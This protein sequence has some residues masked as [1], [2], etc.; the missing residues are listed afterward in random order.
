MPLLAGILLLVITALRAYNLIP[1]HKPQP[2]VERIQDYRMDQLHLSTLSEQYGDYNYPEGTEISFNGCKYTITDN[3]AGGRKFE[4]VD[5]CPPLLLT[6]IS[7]EK[8]QSLIN[9]SPTPALYQTK[10]QNTQLTNNGKAFQQ[11][12]NQN[13]PLN[14]SNINS[15]YVRCHFPHSG[16][17]IMKKTECDRLIDCQL[18]DTVWVLLTEDE[19][20]RK[21]EEYINQ[22]VE[23]F[24]K[25]LSGSNSQTNY[26]IPTMQP[27]PTFTPL[28]NP[29]INS[30]VE[31]NIQ[32]GLTEAQKI[33]CKDDIGALYRQKILDMQASLR[34]DAAANSGYAIQREKELLNEMNRQITIQCGL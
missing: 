1:I 33:Q 20:K 17:L 4:P 29:I 26:Q 10:I 3:H 28:N 16:V 19:C 11:R 23:E 7:P 24:S 8:Y 32:Q 6:P 18:N 25:S 15:D 22:K 27:F 31:S 5:D 30:G 13:T 2:P 12:G 21:Q 14:S 9:P 34:G